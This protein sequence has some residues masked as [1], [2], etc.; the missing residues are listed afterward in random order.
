M[1]VFTT[2]QR[3]TIDK[4]NNLK[5]TSNNS[6]LENNSTHINTLFKQ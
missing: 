2:N 4:E 1:I 6:Q 5:E 3:E